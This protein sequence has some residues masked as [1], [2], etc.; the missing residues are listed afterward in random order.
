MSTI[1]NLEIF[2]KNHG[3]DA[4]KPS[5]LEFFK[6]DQR[7]LPWG[8][9][10][11]GDCPACGKPC[12]R[13]V[14]TTRWRC[15]YCSETGEIEG[16]EK[17]TKVQ[18]AAEKELAAE[19]QAAN[20]ERALK[21]WDESVSIGS[22]PTVATYL[23]ARRL[24]LPPDPDGVMR[25]HTKCPF[26]K[27]GPKP[28]VVSLFRN[29]KTDEPTGIH[30]TW[31]T[32]PLSGESER[33]ALGSFFGS[34]IKLWP[35]TSDGESLTIGEGIENVLAAVA[36][37]VGSAPAW[38]ATVAGNLGHIPIIPGIKQLTIAADND[39]HG[40]GQKHANIL[41]R[42]Y[43]DRGVRSRPRCLTRLAGTSTTC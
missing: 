4:D 28:C 23:G 19:K 32:S 12:F 10:Q 22:N 27:T 40:K 5:T 8:E 26:D 24:E 7:G 39:V 38:A 36:L 21:I 15:F 41:R 34:A 37:G 29:A 2:S 35:L 42:K 14:G 17:L 11:V 30:R 16:G 1:K 18:V 13:M 33:R 20:R 6:R 25:W 9:E 31:I 3:L 43:L